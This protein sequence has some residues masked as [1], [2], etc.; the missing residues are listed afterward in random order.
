[1]FHLII[2]VFFPT[3][4][5]FTLLGLKKTFL[6]SVLLF[7]FTNTHLVLICFFDL[8]DSGGCFLLVCLFWAF[9]G[10]A[11]GHIVEK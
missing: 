2:F 6:P 1:M 11:M 7:A 8:V 3:I 9:L 5:F 10:E 4:F